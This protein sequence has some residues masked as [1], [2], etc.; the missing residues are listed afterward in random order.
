MAAPATPTGLLDDQ[1]YSNLIVLTWDASVGATGYYLYRSING[2][3]TY[4][5]LRD[6][7]GAETFY[8][9][10]VVPNG[11]L[12]LYKVSAYN[13]D[14]ASVPSSPLSTGTLYENLKFIFYQPGKYFTFDQNSY[15]SISL[16]YNSAVVTDGY[17]IAGQVWLDGLIQTLTEVDNSDSPYIIG[18]A[19]TIKVDA[20]DGD[21]TLYLPLVG[22]NPGRIVTVLKVDETDNVVTIEPASDDT[23]EGRATVVLETQY[24]R[25]SLI[26]G[27]GTAD[28]IWYFLEEEI[29]VWDDLRI[30]PGSFDFPGS[31]D[32][33]LGDWQPGG[34]GATL[35]VFKFAPS[36]EGFF[37]CQL[38]HN[39][40]QGSDIKCHVHWT[41]HSR[42]NEENGSTVAW[43]LDYSWS[44][45]GSAF[46]ASATADMTD[47]CSGADH[48]HEVTPEVTIAGSGKTIS[49]MLVCRVYRDTGDTWAGT[50]AN[51]PG[52]LEID[53][54][55]QI[56]SRGSLNSTTKGY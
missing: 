4:S 12:Y 40:K 52:M 37:T 44:N 3:V 36:D 13:D 23:I 29:T 16:S 27:S 15:N 11:V 14:G 24:D 10:G 43:K 32:P 47:T 30:V 17:I 1:V 34:S 8:D 48:W 56:D 5:L 2:G 55:Y 21:V 45:I 31:H 19:G 38:P 25:V 7:I 49:S 28:E 35:K 39:Y 53:F 33:V 54:H 9:F 50:G 42:G 6:V 41:P 18:T 51:A 26:A 20:T 46:G 22:T